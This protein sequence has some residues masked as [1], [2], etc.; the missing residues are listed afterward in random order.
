MEVQYVKA[1]KGSGQYWKSTVPAGELPVLAIGRRAE[2][3]DPL[4]VTVSAVLVSRELLLFQQNQRTAWFGFVIAVA[5]GASVV[6][7]VSDY[8][9]FDKQH[10]LADMTWN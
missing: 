10:R 6:G 5:A 7:F 4:G 3:G 2:G 8:R 9:A 1:G